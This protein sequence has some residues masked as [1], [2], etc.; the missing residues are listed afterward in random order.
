MNKH[1]W[2]E[3]IE[4][5]K[6]NKNLFKIRDEELSEYN[7]IRDE[8]E[9]L[10]ECRNTEYAHSRADELLCELLEDLGYGKIVEL[11]SDVDKWYA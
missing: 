7:K 3:E 5:C 9:L 10:I 1:N 4:D 11:Y 6:K 2:K 8:M